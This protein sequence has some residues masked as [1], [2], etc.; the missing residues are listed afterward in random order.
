MVF[1]RDSFRVFKACVCVCVCVYYVC[2][3]SFDEEYNEAHHPA[4]GKE[5]DE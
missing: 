4:A 5:A 3:L 2:L 1:E